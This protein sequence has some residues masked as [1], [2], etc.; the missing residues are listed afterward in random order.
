MKWLFRV[1]HSEVAVVYEW[2]TFDEW[3]ERMAGLT[4][5]LKTFFDRVEDFVDLRPID[6][7]RANDVVELNRRSMS[8]SSE[9]RVVNL[10]G[11]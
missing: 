4:Q 6:G 8:P 3:T 7:V 11:G 10:L 2:E 9:T 5:F 1:V